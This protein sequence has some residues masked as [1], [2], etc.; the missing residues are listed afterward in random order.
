MPTLL[1]GCCIHNFI[2]GVLLTRIPVCL[3]EMME[4][5]KV[6]H[7]L[8]LR[9]GSIH[10]MRG[11]PVIFQTVLAAAAAAAA[12]TTVVEG[13]LAAAAGKTVVEGAAMATAA[14]AAAPPATATLLLSLQLAC[15][16]L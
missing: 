4:S 10:S 1:T 8:Q 6:S 15:N 16:V 12:G 3:P 11:L 7:R 2:I 14:A 9:P 5:R 13:V